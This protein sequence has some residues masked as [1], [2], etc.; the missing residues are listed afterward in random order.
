MIVAGLSILGGFVALAAVQ[1]APALFL[2]VGGIMLGLIVCFAITMFWKVSIHCAVATYVGLAATAT[3]P[4]VGPV[5][6]LLFSSLI[7]WSRVRIS[8]HTPSQVLA[9]QIVGCAIY[10]ARAI[11]VALV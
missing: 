10:L 2:E 5:A 4:L 3:A 7:G 8:H 6:A 11:L 1:A 9:G